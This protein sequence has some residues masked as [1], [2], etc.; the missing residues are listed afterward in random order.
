MSWPERVPNGVWLVTMSG[1]SAIAHLFPSRYDHQMSLC[2][3]TET[4]KAELAQP[5]S[6]LCTHCQQR[7]GHARQMF[8][9]RE[10]EDASVQSI[11][12]D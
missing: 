4:W 3:R 10:R 12:K 2:E 8:D 5:E 6:K 7:E 9:K 1:K 11:A